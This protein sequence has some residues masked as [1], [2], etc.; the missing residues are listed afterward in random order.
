MFNHILRT[1]YLFQIILITAPDTLL[2]RG[3]DSQ[4]DLQNLLSYYGGTPRDIET[5]FSTAAISSSSFGV[6][7]M[8]FKPGCSNDVAITDSR[9]L[10]GG[11][12]ANQTQ[13]MLTYTKVCY[14]TNY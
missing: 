4:K 7:N 10:N 5:E 9:V 11:L 12:W 2:S 14:D 6:L 8:P 13:R 3:N 1:V